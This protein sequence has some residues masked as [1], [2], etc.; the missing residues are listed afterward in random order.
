MCFITDGKRHFASSDIKCWKFL[1]ESTFGNGIV[2]PL[3]GE[4]CFEGIKCG[5]AEGVTKTSRMWLE[6]KLYRVRYFDTFAKKWKVEFCTEGELE[7]WKSRWFVNHIEVLEEGFTHTSKGLYSFAT[8]M[9]E[10]MKKFLRMMG[11]HGP[12]GG[13][14]LLANATIP[15]GGEYFISENGEHF[16]SDTLRVDKINNFSCYELCF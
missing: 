15:A 7:S 13:K 12:R 4:D 8:F 1:A 16:M 9:T 10:D 6:E 3:Y 5:W 14:L 2:S 11:G